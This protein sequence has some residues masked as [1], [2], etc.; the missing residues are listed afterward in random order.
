[1]YNNNKITKAVRLA[2]MVSA[3]VVTVISVSAFSAEEVSEE[4]KVERI[5]V[6]GSRISRGDLESALPVTI[7]S[8]EAIR[9][10]GLPDIGAVIAQMPFNSQ[11]SFVSKAGSSA[12]NHSASGLR[13]LGSNRTLTLI[14]GKRMA[15]SAT[16]DGEATNLNLIP[17]EAVERID[18]LRDGAG[19]IYGSDA[20]GGVI[21]IILKR[22]FEGLILKV[23]AG[24][25]SQKSGDEDGF[26][27]TLGTASDKGSSLIVL[28]HKEWEGIRYG[29]RAPVL[30]AD[31]SIPYNRSSLY[32]PEGNYH[33][34]DAAGD[35]NGD[36]VAGDCPA[37]RKIP[38]GG[39]ERCGY[40]FLDGKNFIP[41]RI[42]D[43]F[44]GNFIYNIADNVTWQTEVMAMRDTTNTASTSVWTPEGT[45]MAKDNVNNP[46]YGTTG[47][48]DIQAYTRLV[49][50]ADR[51]TDFDSNVYHFGSTL[52]WELDAGTVEFFGNASRQDVN[53]VQEHYILR[54]KY[55]EAVQAGLYNPFV[56]GGDATINTLNSFLHTNTRRAITATKGVGALWASE[57]NFELSGGNLAYSVGGEWQDYRF[58]DKLDRQSSPGGGA[59]PTF[60]GNSGGERTYYA[61]FGE[62]DIPLTK[63]L[64]I[65]LAS[66]YDKYSVPDEGQLSSAI[67]ARYQLL[68][69]IVVRAS[70][71]QGFRAPS[72][73]DLLSEEA[74]SFNNVT[75][76]IFCATLTPAEQA[77][78]DFCSDGEQIERRSEGN[79]NLQPELSEQFSAG[80]IWDITE[81]V[82]LTLDY[83][84]IQIDDQVQFLGAQD[85][86]D[87]EVAGLLNTFDPEAINITRDANQM[88]TEIKT[89]SINQVG[90]TTSGIDLA[91]SASIETDSIGNFSYKFGGSYV[92]EYETQ[93][94]PL[95]ERYDEVG[96]VSTP[97][98]RFNTSF[99][100]AISDF[101]AKLTY[102]YIPTY[103]DLTVV[104]KLGGNEETNQKS[105]GIIDINFNYDLSDF[106]VITFGVRNLAD[107]MPVLNQ[108]FRNGF[109][110]NNHSV[111]GRVLYG[112]Y[113]ITF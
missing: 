103:S 73:D 106:G 88:I 18:I 5:Q 74:L 2:V 21:N 55:D 99:G 91:F 63:D 108:T 25:P 33:P 82:D 66:R 35:K 89:G 64:S 102:R 80:L 38:V 54:D 3:G 16:N 72:I 40:S 9:S 71:S 53:L 17:L 75:D 112:S 36:W 58:E 95:A 42:K 29:T 69:N 83:Y 37:D 113:T 28:E 92:L 93:A 44:F 67:N 43:S 98:Y 59:T 41:G 57:T 6:T 13:G 85:V 104:E 60:G 34:V 61:A 47:A 11:G 87:L 62:L 110:A 49:G 31:W 24:R 77:G 76:P 39:G 86:V 26:S 22:D 105:W 52:T 65:K 7:I 90:T 20:I 111:D 51:E 50:V 19:A 97:K 46:T 94:T 81:S 15:P 79:P 14:N 78:N 84:N 10:T 23:D 68:D 32:A 30:N 107:K 27:L 45:F 56:Q 100:Y 12:G 101:N 96:S 48:T 70:F 4:E 1:M 8:S 109:D